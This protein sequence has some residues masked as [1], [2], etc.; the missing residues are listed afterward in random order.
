MSQLEKFLKGQPLND[1][2][3]RLMRGEDAEEATEEAAPG[4]PESYADGTPITDQDRAHLQRL[5]VSAGWAVLLKLLDTTLQHQ[6]D[7]ARK[8]SLSSTY[9]SAAE[10]DQVINAWTELA[11]DKRAR[12]KLIA[13]LDSEIKKV[14]AKKKRCAPGKTKTPTE[15]N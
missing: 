11:A 14:E 2:M 9:G 4:R 1:E 13:L 12:N 5:E 8:I 7:S 15:I 10:K 3:A 6:E